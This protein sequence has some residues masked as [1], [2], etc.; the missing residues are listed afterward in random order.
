[1]T[2]A[3]D[4]EPSDSERGA[5]AG[6]GAAFAALV[7]ELR[8]L[9]DLV[10]STSAPGAALEAATDHLAE[11]A[12]LLRPHVSDEAEVFAGK[13]PD[14]PGRGNALLPS[15]ILDEATP[16]AVRGRVT[17]STAHRGGFNTAHGGS[18]A[19]L[20]DEL[21]GRLANERPG[22]TPTASLRVNFRSLTPV[23]RELVVE[24]RF[25][26]QEGRKRFL[27]GQLLDQDGRVLADAEGLFLTLRPTEP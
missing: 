13:R 26:G 15:L 16:D 14:L 23:D 22:A 4:Q 24:A 19:L 3:A 12:A 8:E 1:V 21:L 10:R 9:Q 2:K 25:E 20:F 11:A 6:G 18:V 27:S 5:S 17:F 7:A